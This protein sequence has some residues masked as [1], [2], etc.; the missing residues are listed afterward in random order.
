[1]GRYR[2]LVVDDH[3]LV[4]AGIR[5]LAA[6]TATLE[7]VGEAATGREALKQCQS[8]LPH[9]VFMDI[10]MPEMNGLEALRRLSEAQ[11]HVRVI[12][13]TMHTADQYVLEAI[14]WGAKGYLQKTANTAELETAVSAVMRGEIHLPRIVSTLSAAN[15]IRGASPS[16]INTL[17]PR[18]RETLQLIAEG[19]S[20]KEIAKILRI[21]IKT[22]ET[23]RQQLMNQL[24]IHDVAGLVRYAVRNGLVSADR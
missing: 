12:I 4:R 10:S 5:A 13:L 9:V 18:Q 8:L 2:I 17:T 24:D 7:V 22:V 21:S 11:P 14:R 16:L 6:M 15:C 3:G 19:H 1:M 23:H 20:N